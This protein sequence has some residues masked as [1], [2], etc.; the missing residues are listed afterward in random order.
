MFKLSFFRKIL[1]SLQKSKSGACTLHSRR[2]ALRSRS[3]VL[4]SAEQL[5]ANFIVHHSNRSHRKKKPA[6]VMRDSRVNR[7]S[8]A[9][10]R[11]QRFKLRASAPRRNSPVCLTEV[12]FF[13]TLTVRNR[14]R[15]YFTCPCINSSNSR[16]A[17]CS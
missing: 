7:L 12:C 2:T 10:H 5:L 16:L 11:T 3:R 15:N 8:D 9:E 6:A 17:V 4:Y 13:E 1:A 14:T